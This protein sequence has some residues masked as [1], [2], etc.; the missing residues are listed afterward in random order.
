MPPDRLICVNCAG[1]GSVLGGVGSDAP[2]WMTCGK[3]GG[4][5]KGKT[6]AHAW[7]GP[8][9]SAMDWCITCGQNARDARGGCPGPR[10]PRKEDD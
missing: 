1:T 8:G 4:T 5:G 10:P 7:I 6:P 3:C 2:H 9:S